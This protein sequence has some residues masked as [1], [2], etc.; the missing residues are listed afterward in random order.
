MTNNKQPSEGKPLSNSLRECPICGSRMDGGSVIVGGQKSGTSGGSEV[1]WIDHVTGSLEFAVMVQRFPITIASAYRCQNCKVILL[2]YEKDEQTEDER[3]KKDKEFHEYLL[4][5]YKHFY[6]GGEHALEEKL[7]AFM[8]QGL[9][10]E[11]IMRKI[12]Q[13]E[14]P[15]EKGGPI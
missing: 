15:N 3:A 5:I 1:F 4:S 2:G 10:T 9:S 13:K 7:E 14:K 6:G 8:K 12:I 11:E